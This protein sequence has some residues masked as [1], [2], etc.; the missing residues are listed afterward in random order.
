MCAL[1]FCPER[2]LN[3]YN[4]VQAYTDMFVYSI[5][6]RCTLGLTPHPFACIWNGFGIDSKDATSI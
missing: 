1:E 3:I 5:Y 6:T 2:L 4:P